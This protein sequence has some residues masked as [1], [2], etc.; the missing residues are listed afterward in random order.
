MENNIIYVDSPTFWINLKDPRQTS[1]EPLNIKD[2]WKPI[3]MSYYALDHLN[4]HAMLG[5][6]VYI[7]N[8]KESATMGYV[9]KIESE[10]FNNEGWKKV[11]KDS[12]FSPGQYQLR[13]EDLMHRIKLIENGIKILDELKMEAKMSYEEWLEHK[14][15]LK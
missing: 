11:V 5:N 10:L 4:E 13:K 6:M 2:E 1:T 7:L 15:G 8:D 12:R 9:L 3:Q 14:D